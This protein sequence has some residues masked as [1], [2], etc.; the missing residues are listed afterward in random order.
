ARLIQMERQPLPLAEF[1]AI[2]ER[3][4]RLCVELIIQ[5]SEGMLLTKRVMDPWPGYWHIPGG[6][7]FLGEPMAAAV[8]RVARDELGLNARALKQIGYIEYPRSQAAGFPGWPVGIAWQTEILSGELRL[9]AQA[10][11][12][13]FFK[14]VPGIIVP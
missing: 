13:G 11:D 7:V 1:N 6:T 5:T 4:P 8:E 12:I 9:D 14:E 3:V 2:Y 10:N